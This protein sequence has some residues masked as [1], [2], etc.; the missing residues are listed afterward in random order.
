VHARFSPP[1]AYHSDEESERRADGERHERTRRTNEGT[2]ERER[3]EQCC[4]IFNRHRVADR[5]QRRE[6]ASVHRYHGQRT[7]WTGLRRRSFRP[8]TACLFMWLRVLVDT[9]VNARARARTHTFVARDNVGCHV[10]NDKGIINF[11]KRSC[12]SDDV[13]TN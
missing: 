3:E 7:N 13:I 2:R 10:R 8:R 12:T 4:V 9:S 11:A 1:T 6:R 5:R